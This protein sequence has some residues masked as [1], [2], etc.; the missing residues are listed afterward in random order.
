MNIG[1]MGNNSWGRGKTLCIV[2][3]VLIM[4]CTWSPLMF[5]IY[6][7][8][9]CTPQYDGFE[10]P[11]RVVGINYPAVSLVWL[12]AAFV[13]SMVILVLRAN[14]NRAFSTRFWL[15]SV[16]GSIIISHLVMW[17]FLLIPLCFLKLDLF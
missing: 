1:L 17:I 2:A 5:N 10:T 15:N 6:S 3:A 11:T 9:Y 8:T 7:N 14:R 4:L 13:I 16:F 12:G